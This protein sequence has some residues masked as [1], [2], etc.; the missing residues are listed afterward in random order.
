M[1]YAN[2]E[3]PRTTL[4]VI[5]WTKKTFHFGLLIAFLILSGIALRDL[6]SGAKTI[7]VNKVNQEFIENFPSFSVCAYKFMNQSQLGN[8]KLN[9]TTLPFETRVFA[10]FKYKSNK[11][12]I[13]NIDL[14]N[15]DESID[16]LDGEWDLYCKPFSL[17]TPECLPCL[18]FRFHSY[19]RQDIEKADLGIY[20]EQVSDEELGVLFTLH[21][22]NQS[23]L[24]KDSFDWSHTFYHEYSP[25]KQ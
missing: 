15:K 8:G 4:K 12:W 20:I 16:H 14:L 18:T 10:G 9:K 13:L 17:Y 24:L 1:Y 21:D 25:G 6:L 19:K 7:Q 2:M 11:K 5:S 3:R 23:L 22:K